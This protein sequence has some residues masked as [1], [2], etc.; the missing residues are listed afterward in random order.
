M[1]LLIAPLL[2]RSFGKAM[3]TEH[4]SLEVLC[5]NAGRGG[6]AGLSLSLPLPPPLL[7]RPPDRFLSLA[8][9]LTLFDSL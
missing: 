7:P 8:L 2:R 5:L 3:C 9:S 4:G 1:R 6:A